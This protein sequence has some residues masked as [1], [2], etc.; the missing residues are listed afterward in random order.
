MRTHNS[1]EILHRGERLRAAIAK[2]HTDSRAHLRRVKMSTA[3]IA[4]ALSAPVWRCPE[5]RRPRHMNGVLVGPPEVAQTTNVLAPA[6]VGAAL[7][8]S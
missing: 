8:R 6:R 5:P 4:G 1:K 7:R 3:D 2:A